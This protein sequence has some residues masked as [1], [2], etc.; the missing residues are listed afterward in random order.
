MT[1]VHVLYP[2]AMHGHV[3]GMCAIVQLSLDCQKN[4]LPVITV[5]LTSH[6]LGS[7]YILL[8]YYFTPH[9]VCSGGQFSVS[10][11]ATLSF[12]D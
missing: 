9:V 4:H 8:V 12:C 11:K 2:R 1:H 5:T 7:G 3:A 10:F 6:T